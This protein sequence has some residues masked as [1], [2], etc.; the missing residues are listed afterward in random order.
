MPEY[1]MLMKPQVNLSDY[2]FRTCGYALPTLHFF[3][4]LNPT[5]SAIFDIQNAIQRSS[6]TA[7]LSA[8]SPFMKYNADEEKSVCSFSKADSRGYSPIIAAIS[9]SRNSVMT[10]VF[11]I[12]TGD[13]T[14]TVAGVSR[15]NSSTST[16]SSC[17]LI[18]ESPYTPSPVSTFGDSTVLFAAIIFLINLLHFAA[19]RQSHS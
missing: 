7:G 8:L 9:S 17:T 14:N 16:P 13:G 1:H 5:D 4:A 2:L 10:E 15:S 19:A 6:I 12:A 18:T 3:C 11:K